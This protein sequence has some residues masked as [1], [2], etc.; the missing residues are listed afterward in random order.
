MRRFV[1]AA[2]AGVA[3]LAAVPAQAATERDR[4]PDREF[5]VRVLSSP[6]DMV[7]GGDA[8][9][10]VSIPKNVNPKKVT[11]SVNGIDITATL[12]LDDEGRDADRDGHGLE[13]GD[14]ELHVDSNRKGQGPADLRPDARQPSGHRPDLLRPAAAAVR[15]QD[16]QPGARPAARRQPGWD[17]DAGSRRLEQGLLRDDAGRL[18]LPDDDRLLPAAPGRTAAREHRP[19]DDPRRADGALRRPARARHDQP[20]HLLDRDPRPAPV[21][22]PGGRARHVALERPPDLLVQRRRR[23]RLP[24]GHAERRRPPLPQ[25]PLEGLRRRLLDR[26]AHEHALQPR[27][28]RRDGDHDEGALHR[29]VR[30]PEVHGRDRRLRR[31][32]PAVRL[33]AEPQ[34]RGDRRRDP[35]LLVPGHGHADD[36]R[37]RLRAA[38]ALHGRHRR[39]EP[40]VEDLDEPDLAR[41]PRGQQHGHEPRPGDTRLDR[42]HQRLAWPHAARDEP[43][44]RHRGRG[45]GALRPRRDGGGEV[46]A[47]GRRAERLRRGRVRLRPLHVGQRRRPVRPRRAEGR[48]D[49]PDRVPDAERDR[50]Q[51]EGIEGHGAG[52]LPVHRRPLRQPGPVRSLEPAQHAVEPRRGNHSRPE[53]RRQHRGDERRL[54]L[55]ARLPRRHR[56]PGDRLAALPRARAQHAQ[57]APVV[58]RP[59]AD[60]G[61]RRQR[62]ERRHLVHRRPSRLRPDAPG[63][64]RHGRVDGEHRQASRAQRR[65]EQ[66]GGSR[67]QVLQRGRLAD[68]VGLRASGAGSSTPA[69]RARARSASRSSAPRG[70]S[71]AARS[72]AT[73]TSAPRS[74]SPRRSPTGRTD[75]GRRRRP[76]PHGSRR[77]SRRE[78]A[79]TASRTSASRR[80]KEGAS[81]PRRPLRSL[82]R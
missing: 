24:A 28:R 9:V 32:H 75:R 80:S 16:G 47:L 3:V 45:A 25:R 44:L 55:R 18:P 73:S 63:L 62:L 36:P 70:S 20:L 59:P 21:R 81:L 31:R 13:L 30:R 17:R 66:A 57:L 72:R 39:G 64:R 11:V 58:R 67:R 48:A 27:A 1:L 50:R 54:Q 71:R 14:N 22:W 42:V 46:D 60:A 23:D 76:R 8:L 26:D 29:G 19:D 10:E 78:S 74:R 79:T 34:G 49:H 6:A 5:D 51:L 69:R 12:D 7:T 41:G 77:S 53:A 65:R 43:A 4:E 33:R 61:L 40:E 38:R 37:R 56:H 35:G 2:L 15:L 68:R 82:S 52:G